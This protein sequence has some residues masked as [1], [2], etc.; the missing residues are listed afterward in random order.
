MR[1]RCP[2]TRFG[3]TLDAI[4][5]RMVALVVRDS[6]RKRRRTDGCDMHSCSGN[7]YARTQAHRHVPCMHKR[8]R[9]NARPHSLICRTRTPLMIVIRAVGTDLSQVQFAFLK[10][11]ACNGRNGAHMIPWRCINLRIYVHV[12]TP[13]YIYTYIYA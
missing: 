13:A 3:T 5:C 2:P 4:L 1:C 10:G 7:L 12:Y 8:E 9:A 11:F 6:W